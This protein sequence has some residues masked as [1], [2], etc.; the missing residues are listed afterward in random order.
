MQI[1]KQIKRSS[2]FYITSFCFPKYC[3]TDKRICTYECRY[4]FTWIW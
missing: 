2:F 3:S 4:C 1:Q